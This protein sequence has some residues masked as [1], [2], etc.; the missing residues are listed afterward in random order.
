MK[1]FHT[2]MDLVKEASRLLEGVASLFNAKKHEYFFS[3][4]DTFFPKRIVDKCIIT[5]TVWEGQ[6]DE[7]YLGMTEEAIEE[8]EKMGKPKKK[9]KVSFS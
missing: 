5:F 9:K 8:A 4:K 2:E 1:D 3:L 6:L 7:I